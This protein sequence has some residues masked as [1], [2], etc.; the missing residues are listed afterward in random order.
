MASGLRAAAQYPASGRD[1][2]LAGEVEAAR[3]FCCRARVAVN[4]AER[5]CDEKW[6][7]PVHG[8]KVS[9]RAMLG[10]WIFDDEAVERVFVFF[11]RKIL[12]EK[13]APDM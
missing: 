8:G 9:N 11:E 1:E 4:C 3:G 6:A 2:S 5:G 13:I 12:G 7:A 10:E